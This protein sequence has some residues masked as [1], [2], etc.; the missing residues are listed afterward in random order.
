[1]TAAEIQKSIV[2]PNAKITSGYP[3]NVMPSTFGQSIS[4]QDLK[5]LVG[6]LVKEAGKG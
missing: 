5:L 4:P 6:F 2:D 3:P 1:M